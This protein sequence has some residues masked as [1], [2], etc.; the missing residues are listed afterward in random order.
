MKS[1][2]NSL[3]EFSKSNSAS[4]EACSQAHK[5]DND[6]TLRSIDNSLGGKIGKADMGVIKNW[7]AK[8]H[9]N[10]E[11]LDLYKDVTTAKNKELA[12]LAID[13]LKSQAELIREQLRTDWNHQY[14]ALAE[15]AAVGEMTVIRKLEAVF[16]TG[17]DL[18]YG[19]RA[20][21]IE[22]L[23]RRYEEGILSEDDFKSEL[24]YVFNRYK[25]LRDDF[26]QIINQR[27]DA[28]KNSFRAT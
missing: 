6:I 21:V 14:A 3:Y 4:P 8:R 7:Q 5:R 9:A 15:Q 24:G 20:S 1:N 12:S 26:E 17:R 22:Q 10:R 18:L 13:A 23:E 2:I 16:D 19:D 28:I 25:K 11:E 27:G